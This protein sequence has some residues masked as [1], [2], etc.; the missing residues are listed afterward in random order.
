MPDPDPTRA[1]DSTQAQSVVFAVDFFPELPELKRVVAE[2]QDDID[3]LI[4]PTRITFA[5]RKGRSIANRV[6][7]NGAICNQPREVSEDGSWSQRCNGTRCQSCKL[8]AEGGEVFTI[9][10]KKCL[11]VM[12]VRLS[13]SF[14]VP[15]APFVSVRYPWMTVTLVKP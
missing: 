6:L 5:A 12:T 15:N 2:L 10:G 8:M 9:N 7:R 13:S 3:Q 14:I 11:R 4:G 1:A